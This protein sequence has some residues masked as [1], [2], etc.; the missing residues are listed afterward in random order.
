MSFSVITGLAQINEIDMFTPE[1]LA[2]KDA[3]MIENMTLSRCFTYILLTV[4]E[5]G[6]GDRVAKV[7]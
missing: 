6:A 5:K 7:K 2:L 3:E 1:K 4:T